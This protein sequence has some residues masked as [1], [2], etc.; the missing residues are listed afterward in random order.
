MANILFS[1]AFLVCLS[2]NIYF[3]IQNYFI[4]KELVGD[5]ERIRIVLNLLNG[6]LKAIQK[7]KDE[8]S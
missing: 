6:L 4:H 1:L 2:A 8:D 5:N 3:T 7:E